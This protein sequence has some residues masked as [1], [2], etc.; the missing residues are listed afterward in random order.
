MPK[1]VVVGDVVMS[2]VKVFCEISNPLNPR[3][4]VPISQR[5]LIVNLLH[6]GD[7]PSSKETIKRAAADYYWPAMSKDI[8]AF[9]RSCHP[10][11]IAKQSS[12]VQPGIGHFPVPDDRFSYIHIDV[13]GPLPESRGHRYLLSVV[14]RTS[15]WLELYPMRTASAAEYS[16]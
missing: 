15:R 5:N 9:V 2:G 8:T 16:E 3:P 12:T 13:V 11:Q 10:C 1:N 14:D 6:H 4:V 7:H